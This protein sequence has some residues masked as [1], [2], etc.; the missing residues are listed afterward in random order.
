MS[1]LL[2]PEALKSA[3]LEE[4]GRLGFELAGVADAGRAD[5]ADAYQAWV[6]AGMAGEMAY[7]GRDPERRKDPKRVLPG[8]ESILVVGRRYPASLG[9]GAEEPLQGRLASYLGRHDP[10]AEPLADYHDD[11][12]RRLA[13]LLAAARRWGGDTVQGRWYV[14]TG[15]LLERDVARRAGLGWVGKNTCLL[16]RTHGS[17]FF[18]GAVL[19]N[20]ELPADTPTSAHCGTCSRCLTACPTGAFVAP[21]ILDARRC[22]SYLTIELKGP[23]PRELRPLVGNWIFGCDLCQEVCPWNRKA[24]PLLPP[25]AEDLIALL[26]LTPDAF[27]ARFRHTPVYRTKRRGLLRNVCVALGNSGRVEAVAPLAH[28]LS[29]EEPLVRGHA[30]W[31]LGRL[32][33]LLAVEALRGRLRL[34][35]DPWVC[36]ELELAVKELTVPESLLRC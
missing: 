10:D 14:D 12:G 25:P 23:I 9:L 33:D 24:P 15:P 7:L 1:A 6:E 31:A 30:A 29:H 28:A 17:Y 26:G 34:E 27:R 19:L 35:A 2:S 5:T 36:E 11:L 32:G 4:A 3:L 13:E 22:I 8:A 18:L 21:Y 16:N 20:V